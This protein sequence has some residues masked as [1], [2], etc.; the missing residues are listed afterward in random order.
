MIIDMVYTCC[1]NWENKREIN[2]HYSRLMNKICIECYPFGSLPEVLQLHDSFF[3]PFLLLCSLSSGLLI[4]YEK[5]KFAFMEVVAFFS[6][7]L[8]C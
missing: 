4:L 7:I 3:L 2:C 6:V 1:N 8:R 5:I